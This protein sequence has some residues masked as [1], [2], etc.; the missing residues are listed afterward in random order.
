[1]TN[2]IDL[3]QPVAQLVKDHPE[4]KEI[5]IE[6]GFKPL[7]NPVMLKTVGQTTSLKAGSKL[8]R[9]PLETIRQTLEFNGYE[10]KGDSHEG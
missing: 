5:L 4:L 6:L 10:V 1:M 9:V 3:S 2:I 8:A 7:A